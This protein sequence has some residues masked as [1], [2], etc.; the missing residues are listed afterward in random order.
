[1]SNEPPYT[2]PVAPTDFA[3]APEHRG[4]FLI[5]LLDVLA[6]LGLAARLAGVVTAEELT[7]SMNEIIKGID[8]QSERCG[9][10]KDSPSAL[11]R[12]LPARLLGQ[13]FAMPF[14]GERR[15]GVVAGG[16]AEPPEAA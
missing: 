2:A 7:S 14:A 11:A 9:E 4:D 1:M 8:H 13:V 10:P 16:K 5:G 15:F 12:K 6:H 3:I